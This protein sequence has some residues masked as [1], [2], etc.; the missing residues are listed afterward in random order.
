MAR[1]TKTANGTPLLGGAHVIE[2]G[3]VSFS[4]IPR[5]YELPDLL[6]VQVKSFHEFL[7][8][9]VPIA[10][11]LATGL[12]AVFQLNFPIIDSRETFVLEYLDYRLEK[13]RY[14]VQECQERGLTFSVPLKT[15]LRLSS[16]NQEEKSEDFVETVEQEVFLGYNLPDDDRARDV[17]HPMRAER[18]VVSP[19]P[20]VAPVYSSPKAFTR[21]ARRSIF[22]PCY[23]IP[24]KLVS[25]LHDGCSQCSTGRI[26]TGKRN[27][28]SAMLL[29]ALGW[30]SDED[31]LQL[32][33]LIQDIDVQSRRSL[34]SRS[35]SSLLLM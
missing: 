30:S 5:D 29:R 8:E 3:R 35:A 16:K 2:G 34:K 9:G 4:K 32:F 11:R 21:T 15:R 27:S 20:S 26:S 7:Q 23:S 19:A 17:H 25:R 24:W 28:R 31:I 33:G 14:T 22:R 12:E 13:P 18:V 1:A 10:E 6:D